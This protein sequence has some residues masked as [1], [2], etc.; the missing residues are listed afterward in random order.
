M[1]ANCVPNKTMDFLN[2]TASLISH[3]YFSSLLGTSVGL[4]IKSNSSHWKAL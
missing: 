4:A 1:L 3:I 2:W